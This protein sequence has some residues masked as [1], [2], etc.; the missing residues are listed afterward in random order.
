MR[1]KSNKKMSELKIVYS[2]YKPNIAPTNRLISFLRG[3]DELG[4][5]TQVTFIYP[6]EKK[7][8]LDTSDFSHVYVNYLWKE[9]DS[10]NKIVKYLR[11][12]NVAKQY[13]RNL[14]KG[15]NVLLFGGSEYAPFFTRRKD[16]N[17]Y[18]ERTEHYG[19]VQMHPLFLQRRYIKAIPQ[20][21]G[22]FVI[23]TALREAYLKAGAKNV[24]IVNMTVDSN[25]FKGLKKTGGVEPYIAYCGTASNNK[26]GV[27][28]LIKAFAIVHKEIPDIKLWI[29]GR[30]PTKQDASGNKDLVGLLGLDDS[31]IFKGVMPANEMPQLLKDATI[32]ALARPD[33]LQAQCGF[34]TKLGEYLL[35]ETPVVV[36]KVGDIPLFLEDGKTA[37]LAEQKNPEDFAQR[38]LW[39][40]RNSEEAAVI[41]RAGREVALREFNYLTEVKKIVNTILGD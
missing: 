35:S 5:D 3:L 23:S 34:P 41:G 15:T 27:D 26:D 33:S 32:V 18:Q 6:N 21:K 31:V 8:R 13:A 37:L 22:M 24:V 38:I 12:F 4:I 29:I 36:T 2:S 39:A 19:V 30:A 7:D 14:D 25:R 1:L 20:F 16:L 9:D 28:D 10:S 11:S 40:L 17:V